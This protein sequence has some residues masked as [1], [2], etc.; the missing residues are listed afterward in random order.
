MSTLDML[1]YLTILVIVITICI[2]AYMIRYRTFLSERKWFKGN[3]WDPIE[4]PEQGEDFAFCDLCH[5][6]LGSDLI[7]SCACGKRFHY[8][9]SEL[10]DCPGCGNDLRHM[11]IRPPSMIRCPICLQYAP[12]GYC[13]DCEITL[14]HKDGTFRCT[15]C[16]AVVFTSNPTCQK[17]GKRFVPRITKGY[18]N[19]VHSRR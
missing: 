14:P 19:R 2:E 11:H 6:P 10:E 7:A 1:A 5:G 17:C 18:M 16:G 9:C 12:G 15:G 8:E 3:F 4:Y 13:E